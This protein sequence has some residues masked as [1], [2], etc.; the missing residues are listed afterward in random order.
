[1][2]KASI[3]QKIPRQSQIAE[4]RIAEGYHLRHGGLRWID[5][6]LSAYSRLTPHEGGQWSTII[7]V[8]GVVETP[9]Y[10]KDAEAIFTAQER[11][12]L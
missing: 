9:G 5:A 7:S 3:A 2:K 6:G 8:H 1:L 10:L 4:A 12:R 11:E